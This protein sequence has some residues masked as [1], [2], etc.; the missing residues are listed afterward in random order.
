MENKYYTPDISEFYVGFEFEVLS[1]V[2]QQW[3]KQIF[4]YPFYRKGLINN[5]EEFRVKYLD[6]QDIESLEFKAI[7]QIIDIKFIK[8]SEFNINGFIYSEVEIIKG[9]IGDILYVQALNEKEIRPLFEG[10]IK[11]ISELKKLLTQLNIL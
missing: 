9:L 6:S 11:N 10:E 5:I 8:K 7:K 2:T 4:E 3:V 1:N